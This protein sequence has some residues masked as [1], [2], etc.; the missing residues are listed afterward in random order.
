MRPYLVALVVGAAL[1]VPARAQPRFIDDAP[2]HA[3]QFVD[4][5]VG[6]AVGD[7]GVVWH[8]IDGGGTW[9]P[10]PTGTRAALRSLHFIDPLIGWVAGRE[11][12]P[13]GGS[14]GVLFYTR[15]GGESWLRLLHNALPGINCVRFGDPKTGYLL[16]DGNDQYGS[17]VF[18]TRDGGRTWQALAGPRGP[19]WLA[20]DFKDGSVGALVGPW[21][22]LGTLSRDGFGKVPEADVENLVDRNLRGLH[23][24]ATRTIA[25]GQGGLVLTSTSDGRSYGFPDLKLP[26]DVLKALDFHSVHRAG[27]HVWVAGRPGSV[28]LHSARQGAVG[29]WHLVRTGQPLPLNAVHFFDEKRGWAVGEY[30]VILAT[31]DGGQNWKVQ[32]RGGQ[33]AAVLFVNARPAD[34]PLDTVAVLGGEEGH[35]TTALRVTAA[36]ARSAALRRASDP[37]R[38]AAAVRQA[39]GG[40]GELLWQFPVPQHLAN[41]DKQELLKFW[42]TLHGGNADRELVRQLVLALRM[43]RPDVVVTDHPDAKAADNAAGALVA[44]ALHEAFAQAADPKAFPEQIEHLG[45]QPWAASK[46]YAL[47]GKRQD[48]QVTVDGTADLPRLE[49]NARDFAAAPACALAEA[50]VTL[51]AERNYRLTD[52]RLE[53]ALAHKHLLGGVPPAGAGVCR[54]SLAPVVEQKPEVVKAIRDC[55]T[56]RTLVEQP[57]GLADAEKMLAQ[58]APA[59]KHLPPE[60]GATALYA[61][62]SQYARRGQWLLAR[63][64]YLLLADRYPQHPHAVDAYRWLVRH[65]SSSEARRRQELGQFLAVG[66]TAFPKDLI[67]TADPKLPPPGGVVT[68]DGKG[69]FSPSSIQQVRFTYLTNQAESREWFRGSVEVAKK[70][71]TLGPLFATDPSLQFCVQAARRQLGDFAP[72]QEWYGNFRLGQPDGPWRDAAAQELWLTSR[73][74]MPPRP[75]AVCRQTEEKPYLDGKFD[76]ACWQKLQPIVLQNAVRD[77]VKEYPTEVRLAYDTKFL[78]LAVRC[79][80]PK[81]QQVAPVQARPRDADL[82]PFDRVSLMLDLDRDYSTYFRLE[83]DQRGCVCEDCW[84]DKTWNPQ[85]FVAIH[86]AEEFWQVEAAIP[87]HELTKDAIAVNTAWACNVVRT[88][89]GRGVQAMSVPADVEPRPEGMGLVLFHPSGTTPQRPAPPMQPIN[90]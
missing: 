30:G 63:E 11:E 80:H 23:V 73:I 40:S 19:G 74:G 14:A 7:D 56:V 34:C 86:S 6:W 12:L 81:G 68:A 50:P 60:H 37:Q 87:L 29:T 33:R 4:P 79:Q 90:P 20:G 51:P 36:D 2:L 49:T 58:L 54:R 84:G 88:L 43:W 57:N 82:R 13:G 85:W 39:G 45:L 16:C 71:T 76:D 65:N 22:R 70:L 3:I 25:V 17:G 83:I 89:P 64:A 8:T 47:W 67:E 75:V 18:Q 55:R 48:T 38:F 1:A 27:D 32:Q 42:N 41:A 44:E 5:K 59:L 72:A 28:L 77:T 10:Q 69:Q 78:Y 62:A 24:G 31:E 53:N 46:A 21:S 26:Q 66:A 35:L 61:V 52:N 15:D 9:E